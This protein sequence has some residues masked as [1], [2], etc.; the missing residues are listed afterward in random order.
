MYPGG[1]YLAFLGRNLY[2]SYINFQAM[3]LKSW[4]DQK[5]RSIFVEFLVYN[6]NTNVFNT[7]TLLY[8][9]S[10]TGYVHQTINVS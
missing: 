7:V 1:G 5:T 9:Q 10:A 4:I 8:E 3:V 6:V 2:N